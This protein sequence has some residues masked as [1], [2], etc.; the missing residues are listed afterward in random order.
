MLEPGEKRQQ[1]LVLG[2]AQGGDDKT[3]FAA[4]GEGGVLG[5]PGGA[6]EEAGGVFERAVLFR[7]Q[8]RSREEAQQCKGKQIVKCQDVVRSLA[9]PASLPVREAGIVL[10]IRRG[11]KFGGIWEAMMDVAVVIPFRGDGEVLRWALAGFARQQLPADVRV[12]VRLCGDGVEVPAAALPDVAQG[13]RKTPVTFSITN[14][15]IRLGVS[16]AKNVLLRGKKAD[17]VILANADTRPAEGLVAAHVR[18]L[19][20]LPEGSTVL[21]SSPYDAGPNPNVFDILKEETP[22]IFFIRR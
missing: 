10:P 20:S 9:T 21:G 2:G 22:M 15:P 14:S 3:G 16:E 1:I 4:L 5:V 7:R 13:A 6:L 19:L 12:E 17:L 11:V 8:Q 18:R